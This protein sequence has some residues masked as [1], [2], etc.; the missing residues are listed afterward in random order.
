MWKNRFDTLR[1]FRPARR[2]ARGQAPDFETS[3]LIP[4]AEGLSS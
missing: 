1:A 4:T 3:H 2:T